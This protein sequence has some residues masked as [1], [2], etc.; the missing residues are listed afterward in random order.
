MAIAPAPP[1][2]LLAYADAQAA[3]A[4]LADRVT[5]SPVRGPLPTRMALAERQALAGLD[6]LDLPDEAIIID[7]RGRVAATAYDLTHWKQ[8]IGQ[9]IPLTALA[10]DPVALLAWFG[11]DP[12]RAFD[13]GAWDA[14]I[15]HDPAERLAAIARWQ[16]ACRALPPS[17]PLLHS[18]RIAALWRQHA[19]LGRGD[20][21]ASL[22]I[23]DRWGA[24]RWPGSSG[25][26]TAL[27][28]RHAGGLWKIARGAE[29]DRLWLDAI[30]MGAEVHLETDTRLRAYAQRVARHLTA[31]RRLG[32]LK[33]VL[34][35]AMARPTVTSGQ[36]AQALKLTS[37]GA[38]KLLTIAVGEGLL[39]ERTGQASYRSYAIPVSQPAPGRPAPGRRLRPAADPFAA[40]FWAEGDEN[41]LLPE[42]P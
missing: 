20:L 6:S 41:G 24:G 5:L 33:D 34:R 22:L 31:R 26:L 37:A 36:V 23:G 2:L 9:P 16:E 19:P 1:D 30:Q 29:L 12:P 3:L 14:P 15:A 17:P 40:D 38:I 35:F 21:V 4:R 10:H 18:G 28:L 13:P 32:R 8:A 27:G 25:G 39:L 42:P 7:T 11:A